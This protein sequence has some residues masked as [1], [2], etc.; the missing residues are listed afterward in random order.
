[1]AK[2]ISEYLPLQ[3]WEKLFS[4]LCPTA[5]T[6]QISIMINIPRA[7]FTAEFLLSLSLSLS[8]GE[9]SEGVTSALHFQVMLPSLPWQISTKIS[10]THI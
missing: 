6:P 8:C 2:Y 4:F 5:L 10:S 1:M 9:L 3:K 7:F